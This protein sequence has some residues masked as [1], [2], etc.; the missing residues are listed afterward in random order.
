LYW[1]NS[2][3]VTTDSITQV[4]QTGLFTRQSSQLSLANLEDVTAEQNGI[5][6]HAFNYGLLKAETA[7]EHSKFSF[8]YCPNPNLYAQQILHAREQFEQGGGHVGAAP[9]HSQNQL[10]ILSHLSKTDQALD[11]VVIPRMDYY[12]RH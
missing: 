2:W 5:L 3:V 1:G 8:Y 11:L 12:G 7:G 6:A 9:V 4:N 10:P